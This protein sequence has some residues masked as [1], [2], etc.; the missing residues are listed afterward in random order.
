[1]TVTQMAVGVE[2][3]NLMNDASARLASIQGM[4][5]APHIQLHN[6]STPLVFI[7][8]QQC[9][10]AGQ[11]LMIICRPRLILN[12]LFFLILR[13][14]SYL[15]RTIRTR[16]NGR[17]ARTNGRLG[18]TEGEH[19]EGTL[20]AVLTPGLPGVLEGPLR[21][22]WPVSWLVPAHHTQ[23]PNLLHHSSQA[24]YQANSSQDADNAF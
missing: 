23:K 18:L 15:H 20:P 24:C 17:V 8:L 21:L 3:W 11:T 12:Q 19:V 4:P 5:A 13:S 16:L 2:S 10:A 6:S 9:S 7:S 1:M 14:N 22:R